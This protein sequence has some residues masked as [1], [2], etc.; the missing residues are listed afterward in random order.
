[1]AN[2]IKKTPAKFYYIWD[3]LEWGGAQ[4]LFFGIMKEAKRIGEVQVIL[5]TGS[6]SQLLKFLENLGVKYKFFD[7]HTDT[8]IAPTLKRKLE[9]HYR[10][11]NSEFVLLKFLKN[12]DFR[13]SII[14]TELAPWQSLF[15]LW[16]LT[17][18]T[19]VF[20]TM[21][22]ALPAVPKWRFKLWQAKFRLLTR[23]KNF[24]L[25][26][27]NHDT[28]NSLKPLVS[29]RFFDTIKVIYANINPI[30]IDEALN[31]ELNQSKLCA[32]YK[33]PVEKFKVFCVGQFIDRKGRWVFLEAAKKLLEINN[34]IVFV[35]ISNYAA[36]A[37]DLEKANSYGLG[38]NFIFLTSDQIGKEH[39]DLFKMLRLADVFA[40]PSYLEGLP[41]SIIEA[42]ALGIPT[43]STRINAIPEAIKHLE[44]G[45]LIEPGNSDL[46]KESIQKLKVDSDLREKLSK[47]GR[48]YVLEKFDQRK[49]AKIAVESYVEAFQKR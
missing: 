32:R 35:W 16:R 9:K 10:K 39:I 29:K 40:L 27:A 24:H 14:H 38:E 20:V 2:Q 31:A 7:A 37:E 41:I 33:I 30:E 22:N 15:A 17:Q 11:I 19:D 36:S 49:V 6:S 48:D 13:D 4:V 43:I 34:D 28:K 46:L 3:Y 42:M 1:V 26:T 8:Q 12:L 45:L 5:P 18:K 25:F 47:Q 23:S 21:H 44:T